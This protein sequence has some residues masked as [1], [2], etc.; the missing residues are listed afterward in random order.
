[1]LL[2]DIHVYFVPLPEGIKEMVTP[3][4][5]GYTIYI[6]AR[7]CREQQLREYAH[8]VQHIQRDDFHGG[9]VQEIESEVRVTNFFT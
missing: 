5:D 6:D 4:Y 2:E 7:L 8:A 3:C 1:M 9:D